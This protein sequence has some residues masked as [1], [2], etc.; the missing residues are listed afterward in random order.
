MAQAGDNATLNTRLID[1]QYLDT[2]AGGN[3]SSYG[4]TSHHFSVP[5]Q[6]DNRQPPLEGSPVQVAMI[7]SP[8]PLI[9]HTYVVVGKT[10]VGKST[11]CGS[12][13]GDSALFPASAGLHSTTDK[14]KGNVDRQ[15]ELAGHIH[16]I[17]LIDTVGLFDTEESSTDIGI[18]KAIRTTIQAISS[19]VTELTGVLIVIKDE[20][21]TAEGKR[22]LN[23][24][25]SYIKPEAMRLIDVRLVITSKTGVPASEAHR[26]EILKDLFKDG[27]LAGLV[28]VH[29]DARNSANYVADHISFVDLTTPFADSFTR[30]L[31]PYQDEAPKAAV[32]KGFKAASEVEGKYFWYREEGKPWCTI[33]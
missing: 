23:I 9:H 30:E 20:K 19:K 1:G 32:F 21:M 11:L 28:D 26:Q 27:V 24:M 2:K 3:S 25:R 12:V 8:K 15:V 10:G 13:L 22:I 6:T 29:V 16:S 7:S 18:N 33:C 5:G 17:K 31:L 4:P 14:P